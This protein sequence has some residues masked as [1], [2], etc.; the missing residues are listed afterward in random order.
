MTDV[1]IKPPQRKIAK[2]LL[3]ELWNLPN[4]L[5]MLRIAV[6]PAICYF[7]WKDTRV[8]NFIATALFTFAAISDYIDGYLARV[9]N[10]VTVIGKFLDPLA[11]KL[12]VL[13]VLIELAVMGRVP[14]WV[15]VIIMAREVTI[16][17]LR[18]I[19]TTEGLVIAARK[20]GK[21]KTAWQ[22]VALVMLLAH[23]KYVLSFLV[24]EGRLNFHYMG[25]MMLYIS[26]F[27]SIVSAAD[28]FYQFGRELKKNRSRE[29]SA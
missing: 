26:L 5:T 28:Y 9:T 25:L 18:S 21:Y 14:W 15:V 7:L 10:T 1:A 22:L 13:S 4:M 29:A 24:W 8:D 12:A 23:H 6:I 27:F 20:L 16:T 19:A 3:E 11:D 2:T 17:G